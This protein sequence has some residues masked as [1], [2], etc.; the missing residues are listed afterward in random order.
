MIHSAEMCVPGSCDWNCTTCD[1]CVSGG[2]DSLDL[3]TMGGGFP[4]WVTK[5]RRASLVRRV[6]SGQRMCGTFTKP[7]SRRSEILKASGLPDASRKTWMVLSGW[8]FGQ[9]VS[10]KG[11][12]NIC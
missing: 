6:A 5:K 12:F 2:R 1:S 10:C 8:L 9:C 4:V 11:I 7:V 3:K